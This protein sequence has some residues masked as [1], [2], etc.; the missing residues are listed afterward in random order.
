MP[1]ISHLL[2]AEL[3][4]LP[5]ARLTGGIEPLSARREGDLE[6]DLLLLS[7]DGDAD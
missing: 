7:V 4:P 3:G 1:M 6:L 5:Y 2:G